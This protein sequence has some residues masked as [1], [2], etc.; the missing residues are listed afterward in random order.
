MTHSST[1]KLQ[2]RKQA[3][4]WCMR[5]HGACSGGAERGVGVGGC[6]S[7]CY[8]QDG[9]QCRLR[10]AMPWRDALHALVASPCLPLW[11]PTLAPPTCSQEWPTATNTSTL[12]CS[13]SSSSNS[14]GSSGSAVDVT[15]AGLEPCSPSHPSMA[16]T[17]LGAGGSGVLCVLR[18]PHVMLLLAATA[19]TVLIT[20]AFRVMTPAAAPIRRWLL[21]RGA[22]LVV[23]LHV[24][25]LRWHG[26]LSARTSLS[27]VV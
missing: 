5:S 27:L 13:S 2:H 3:K 17:N 22:A 1:R 12:A 25:S 23:V 9:V 15:I 18:L 26:R 10:C 19:A 16:P 8:F 11:L 21:T 14:S 6:C 24:M 7:V 4:S 20:T